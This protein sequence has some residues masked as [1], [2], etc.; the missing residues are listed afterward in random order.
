VLG[1][2]ISGYLFDN[3]DSWGGNARIDISGIELDNA[4]TEV[5]APKTTAK[6]SYKKTVEVEE[7]AD[8]YDEESPY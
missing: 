1:R 8:E 5:V 2:G 3:E 6:R 4:E 7:E